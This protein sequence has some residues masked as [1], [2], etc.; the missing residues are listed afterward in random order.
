MVLKYAIKHNVNFFI[1]TDTIL[2]KNISKY[3]L[4][5]NQFS[6]WLEFYSSNIRC[7]NVRLQH[8]YGPEDNEKRFISNIIIKI[9]KKEKKIDLTKGNQLG[10]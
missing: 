4:S 2:N 10:F 8:F 1:N 9:L 3:A 5:K 7:V 6:D